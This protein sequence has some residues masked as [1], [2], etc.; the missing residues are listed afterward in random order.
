MLYPQRAE[1]I[2][3]ALQ[4]GKTVKVTELSRAM[5]VSVD[6]VRRDLKLLEQDGLIKYVHGGACLPDSMLSFANFSGREIVNAERKRQ[7]ARKAV[8]CVNEGDIVALNS[9]TTN[10]VLAQELVQLNKHFT[11]VTNNYAALNIL[12]QNNQITLVAIGGRVD[13]LERSSYGVQCVREFED[14]IPD[15]SF[16]SIN[17]VN[18]SAGFTD[19]RLNEIPVIKLL[20]KS[21]KRVVAVMDSSKFNKLSKHKVLTLSDV[22]L[23]ITDDEAEHIEIFT[24]A[25]LEV[26]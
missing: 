19:F 3:Q 1:Y 8:A 9:G 12:M 26:K 13:G 18:V 14:Y 7:A 15:I 2:L 5:Q 6:T 11:V 20:A 17:A 23:L 22:D 4:L 25:G 16:L 21:S 24:E 10:T